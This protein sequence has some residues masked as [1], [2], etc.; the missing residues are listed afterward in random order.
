MARGYDDVHGIEHLDDDELAELILQELG[1]HGEIDPDLVDVEVEDGH[2][3]LSGRVGT[4]QE[5]QQVEA[6]VAD[7]L[8][9]TDFSNE[10]VVDELVRGERSEAA[11]EEA[12]EVAEP[13]PQLAPSSEQSSPEAD[14][15]TDDVAG[16]L[17]GSQDPH[18]AITRGQTYEPPTRPIQEGNRSHETH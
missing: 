9:V 13:S 1:E 17:Y 7:V 3:R 14:H 4:E 6:T 11:D 2:V 5:L 18:R 12:A 15:L 10:L 16:D 8:G